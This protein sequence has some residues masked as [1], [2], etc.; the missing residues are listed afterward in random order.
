MTKPLNPIGYVIKKTRIGAVT[1]KR[2]R[3]QYDSRLFMTLEAASAAA[4][5]MTNNW[6]SCAAIPVYP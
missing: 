6:W 1:P 2:K 5:R 3:V 4:D